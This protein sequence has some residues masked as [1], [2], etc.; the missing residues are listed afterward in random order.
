MRF[1]V[2]S[3]LKSSA[4]GAEILRLASAHAKYLSRLRSE[5]RLKGYYLI[6][7]PSPAPSRHTYCDVEVYEAE[8]LKEVEVQIRKSP[9]SSIAD[10]EILPV[11]TWNE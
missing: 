9:I 7:A 3:R 5:D 4:S 1:L 2:I 6:W 11:L 8:S 10:Y